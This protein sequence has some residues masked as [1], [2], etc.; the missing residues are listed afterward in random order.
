VQRAHSAAQAGARAAG[1]GTV[2]VG[3]ECTGGFIAQRTHAR[4]LHDV[5]GASLAIMI[6]HPADVAP[7]IE[8]AV[9]AAQSP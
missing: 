8:D 3:G 9:E 6:S 4:A 1:L 2:A 7:I 5:G